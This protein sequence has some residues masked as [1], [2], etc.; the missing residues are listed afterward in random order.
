V[1]RAIDI[2]VQLDG[3]GFEGEICGGVVKGFFVTHAH[4]NQQDAYGDVGRA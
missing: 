4:G 2:D 3:G 1:L